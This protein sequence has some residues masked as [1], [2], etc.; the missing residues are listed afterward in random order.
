MFIKWIICEVKAKNKEAFSRAQEQWVATASA[1]GFI[2]QAGGWNLKNNS[3]ACIIAFWK[4]EDHLKLFMKELH[5]TI[6]HSNEQEGTYESIHVVHYETQL[7]MEG[8]ANSLVEAVRNARFLRVADCKVKSGKVTHF[9]KV[10]EEI[11]I[12]AMRNSKGMLGGK[13]SRSVLDQNRYLVTTFWNTL[14]NHA[15]YSKNILPGCRQKSEVEDD[16]DSVSG[17]L[18]ELEPSWKVI[19]KIN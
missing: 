18:V 11:W 4:S 5:D 2:A 6:F 12:P 10:Q 3:E 19:G 16:T 7:T 17:K 9:E 1:E 13:F 15:Y 8:S 14:E